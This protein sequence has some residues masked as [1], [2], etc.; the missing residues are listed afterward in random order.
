MN[1]VLDKAGVI[2]FKDVRDQELERAV[3]ALLDEVPAAKTPRR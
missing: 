3:A 2:R 1:F